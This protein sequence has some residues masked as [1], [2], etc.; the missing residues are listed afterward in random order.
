MADDSVVIVVEK[1]K[2]VTNFL[3]NTCRLRQPSDHHLQGALWCCVYVRN[4]AVVPPIRVGELHSIPLIS[5]SSAEF[6]IQ[7][8]LSFIGDVDIMHH[9]S[10]VLAIPEGNPPPTKLPAEFHSRVRVYEIIDG[11]YPGYLYLIMSYLLTEDSDNGKYN[12]IQCDQRHYASH[13]L[14]DKF[15]TDTDFETHGPALTTRGTKTDLSVDRV[16]CIRCLSWPSQAADW[17]TRHRNY[18]WPDSAIINLVVNN[19]C[20]VVRVAHRLCKQDEWMNKAQWRLSFSRAEIVLLNSWMPVQQIVYHMLRAFVKTERLTDITD[21]TGAKIISNYHLKTVMM[22]ASEL[23]PQSWWIDDMN[24]V[25]ICA[26]LLH[27]FADWMKSIA[28]PHYFL[29][30]C[31][32]IY[33]TE[34]LKIIAS[35]LS[36]ITESLL[37]TWFVDNYLRKCAQLCPDRVSRLFDDVSTSMKLQNAVS[38]VV[39]WRR[40]SALIDLWRVCYRAK[41]FLPLSTCMCSMTVLS[42]RVWLNELVN[43]DSCYRGYFTAVA[44]LHVAS[45]IAKRSFN[46]EL[47]DVLA[48]LVGQFVGKQRY[49]HQLSSEMS[50][51]QA[52]ILMK[53]V[54]NNSRSTVQQIELELSKAYLY[55]ALRCK[56]SDSDSMYCLANVYLAVLYYTSGQY[57]TAVDHCTPVMRSQDHSQ[58]SSHV[59]QGD[60]LP[61]VDDDIDIV[62]GLAVFYQYVR[63]DAL[64]QQQTQ[65][66]VVFTTELFA[67]YL[68]IR[69]LSVMKCR[70]LTQ[71][72]STDEV[73]RH[74]KYII[75]LD[76]LFIADGLL[77]RSIITSLELKCHYKPL[78]QQ[79]QKS[80]INATEL[81]TT[82]LVKLL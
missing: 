26:K 64:N 36:S 50:L 54:A 49:C 18:D 56:D 43:I 45:K 3:L 38:A 65:Y 16:P 31:N 59:V 67:R 35:Q 55:R 23:N 22:W 12:Y 78:A 37:S 74:T 60:L 70:Q 62:L 46:D 75:G 77:L 8:M 24:V 17:S 47:M 71:M 30:N 61:K 27:I 42:C 14:Y 4:G 19:G 25:R 82:E 41:Y 51:S 32:L 21:S 10:D 73:Q 58:C 28:C 48:T 2:I 11:E 52:V 1:S 79:R 63:T 76:Q 7:P 81:D 20:D 13:R 80:T 68:Y 34:H 15:D 6:Y 69:C 44:F 39:D 29:N 5:G 40:D 33:N 66:V 9:Q 72:S 53:V 57:Q